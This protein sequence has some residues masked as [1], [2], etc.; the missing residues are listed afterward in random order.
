MTSPYLLNPLRSHAQALADRDS[1]ARRLRS[2][3]D[4]AVDSPA[5]ADTLGASQDHEAEHKRGKHHADTYS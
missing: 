5:Q 2:N 4:L 3:L 1:A